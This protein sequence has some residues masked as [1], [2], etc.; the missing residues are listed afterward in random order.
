MIKTLN[1]KSMELNTSTA[2]TEL[3]NKIKVLSGMQIWQLLKSVKKI[4]KVE[5]EFN[6]AREKLVLEYCTKDENGEPI[7][8]D[9]KVNILTQNIPVFNEKIQELLDCQEDFEVDLPVLNPY[10][11][12]D[13]DLSFSLLQVL[14]N[15]EMIVEPIEEDKSEVQ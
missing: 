15:L 14:D 2:L 4:G 6:E 7:N 3:G 11:L 13:L 8:K 9:G 1:L 10:V 12:S 5:K